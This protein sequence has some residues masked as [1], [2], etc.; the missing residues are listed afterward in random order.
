MIKEQNEE[1]LYYGHILS[2]EKDLYFVAVDPSVT[3]VDDFKVKSL[4]HEDSQSL[5]VNC[6]GRG[7]FRD[8]SIKPIVGDRVLIKLN[9]ERDEG[10]I[11]E[12]LDRKNSMERP[13]VANVDQFLLVQSLVEPDITQLGLDKILVSIELRG[14]PLIICFNKLDKTDEKKAVAWLNL[15]KN[16]GYRVLLTS[17]INDMGMDELR[18]ML[19][20]K[21]SAIAGPS[22]AGKSSIISRLT[23]QNLKVGDLSRKTMRGRQTTRNTRLYTLDSESFI[24]DTPGFSSLS[25]GDLESGVQLAKYFP[26]I[27]RLGKDCKFRNCSHRKE[28]DCKVKEGL[29][30]GLIDKGRYNSYLS[31]LKEIEDRR[32]F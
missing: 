19:K 24:F 17:T 2:S 16:I 9:E 21:I 28:P 26:E 3:E 32:P 15:Y 10:T 13:R 20:G 12:V 6:R 1:D 18:D 30:K 27:G 5:F 31:I 8:K 25:I 23:G 4:F 22:G 14:L 7:V 11:F 29:E